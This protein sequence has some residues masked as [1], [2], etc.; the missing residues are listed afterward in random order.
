MLGIGGKHTI[1]VRQSFPYVYLTVDLKNL[2]DIAKELDLVCRCRTPAQPEKTLVCCTNHECERWMHDECL[3][4][5]VLRRVQLKIPGRQGGVAVTRRLQKGERGMHQNLL[6][7]C[8]AKLC[9]RDGPL[10]WKIVAGKQTW[11][12]DV[13]CLECGSQIE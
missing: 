13:Y 8:E 6:E 2:T 3:R 4:E 9:L 11:F 5:D 12:E 1:A 7:L 10:R